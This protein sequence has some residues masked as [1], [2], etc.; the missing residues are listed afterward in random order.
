MY[1][2]LA[3]CISC[4]LG[5]LSPHSIFRTFSSCKK[6]PVPVSGHSPFTLLVPPSHGKHLSTLCV[7]THSPLLGVSCKWSR[8]CGLCEWPLSLKI[9]FLGFI[10]IVSHMN[11]VF[12]QHVSILHLL[13]LPN[14]IPLYGHTAF[15]SQ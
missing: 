12:V 11:S 7:Y 6:K 4:G 3:F 5:Q 1:S 2:S 8:L 9:I 15:I 10:H 14:N 13:L